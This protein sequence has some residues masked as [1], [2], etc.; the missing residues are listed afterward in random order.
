MIKDV[1]ASIEVRLFVTLIYRLVAV[2]CDSDEFGNAAVLI[3][4]LLLTKRR[5]MTDEE[6]ASALNLNVADVR[7][8]LHL[9]YGYGCVSVNKRVT[10]VE[11][12]GYENRWILTED[13]VRKIIDERASKVIAKLRHYVRR[14]VNT[15]MYL[16]PTCFRRY[17][18][19][20]AYEYEFECPRD[21][22]A[23]IQPELS[24]EIAYINNL[25][26]VIEGGK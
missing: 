9:L 2:S 15:M 16:C 20:E 6:I 3:A 26:K 4:T 17:A 19:D 10:D 5:E 13:I 22:T 23:L 1:D 25:I 14:A 18:A 24:D 21:G 7:R 11:R 12:G 8:V